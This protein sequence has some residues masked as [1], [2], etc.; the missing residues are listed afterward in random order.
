MPE[1]NLR[2]GYE[3]SDKTPYDIIQRRTMGRD[4]YKMQRDNAFL[5]SADVQRGR[6]RHY[7]PKVG[8]D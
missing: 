5:D 1:D 6:E 8:K 3:Y 7:R 4:I 2:Q